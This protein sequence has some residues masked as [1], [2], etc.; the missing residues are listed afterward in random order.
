MSNLVDGL[1]RH[2][3]AAG[4]ERAVAIEVALKAN[5]F[6]WTEDLAGAECAESFIG[7]DALPEQ[8]ILFVNRVICLETERF[9]RM[10]TNAEDDVASECSGLE[11]V[12]AA[13]ASVKPVVTPVN[14]LGPRH[15]LKR[16]SEQMVDRPARE[17]WVKEARLSS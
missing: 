15:A 4:H 16:L 8:D 2:G 10:C 9:E 11:V 1:L 3:F 5:D 13:V 17:A 7:F 6:L 14:G 12:S